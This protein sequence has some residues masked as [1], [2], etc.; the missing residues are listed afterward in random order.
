VAVGPQL[1]E[2]VGLEPGFG[3]TGGG[4]ELVARQCPVP[5]LI[6]RRGRLGLDID[7]QP[8]PGQV[9]GIEGDLGLE[10]PEGPVRP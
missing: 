2:P 9:G 6:A 10:A 4:E 3:P 7:L 5:L 1:D 8:A